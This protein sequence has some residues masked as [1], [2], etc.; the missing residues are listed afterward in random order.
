MKSNPFVSLQPNSTIGLPATANF[1]AAGHY[2]SK[3]EID[4]LTLAYAARRP[5][6]LRGEAGSGKSQ[7]ARAAAAV[8][9]VGDPLV[10]VIHP[11]FDP[12]DLLYQYDAVQR[13]ADAQVGRVHNNAEHYI[14]KGRL[15]EAFE[16]CVTPPARPVLLI[17]EIDKAD[18]DIPN[19]LLD[20]LGNRSFTVKHLGGRRIDGGAQGLPLILVTTNEER[21]LPAA[22]VRRC[23]VLNLNPPN[24]RSH[25]E[26]FV[27]WLVRR[28]R[29][30]QHLL[31][32]N[33]VRHHAAQ[34]VLQ[35]RRDADQAGY[36]K[37]GLA[38]YI[39]LLTALHELTDE[40]DPK[41][42]SDQQFHWLNR[43]S[44]YALVKHAEQ[45]QSREP[46]AIP[47]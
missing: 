27:E 23:I 17:D 20:V 24:H 37:V 18:A 15:W 26:Q 42:R 1:Q 31:I 43:L 19:A 9:E 3:P 12:I 10:E 44:A 2:W 35:D 13:L 16:Q 11:R 6:L 29:V 4:A 32:Q 36:P 25:P 47:N 5:L 22:F 21:E 28:G 7:L 38:E 39:D 30:H 41:L 34:Q 14:L 46:L 8:M 33:E 45:V 40:S